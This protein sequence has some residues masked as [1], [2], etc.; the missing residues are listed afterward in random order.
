MSVCVCIQ[1]V[2]SHSVGSGKVQRVRLIERGRIMTAVYTGST[3]SRSTLLQGSES[4]HSGALPAFVD[5]C[6]D[7][8]HD[9]NVSKTKELVVTFSK[10]GST[11]KLNSIQG[12][13]VEIV[14]Y[15]KYLGTV[16]PN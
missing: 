1:Y 15:F 2:T 16:I 3:C 7:S 4:D 5:W 9:L 14:N 8:C 10:N 6:D 11:L 12:K 13:D